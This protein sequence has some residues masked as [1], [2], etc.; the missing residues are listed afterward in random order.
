MHIV[1]NNRKGGLSINWFKSMNIHTNCTSLIIL[2]KKKETMMVSFTKIYG[3]H[4]SYFQ[5]W[6]TVGYHVV[7]SLRKDVM[8]ERGL[9]AMTSLRGC[10]ETEKERRKGGARR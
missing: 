5:T 4:S 3:D 7:E 2:Q 6:C 1:N 8:K 10:K 9:R